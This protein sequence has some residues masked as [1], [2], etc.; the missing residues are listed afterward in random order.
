MLFIWKFL[1]NFST[2]I[3]DEQNEEKRKKKE[4]PLEQVVLYNRVNLLK[5]SLNLK[6]YQIRKVYMLLEIV[7]ENKV[8]YE[9][10][11]RFEEKATSGRRI[12]ISY[13]VNM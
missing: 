13:I 8:Q 3:Q 4:Q 9:K 11:F 12:Y 6:V 10:D 1:L 5:F 7:D 2:R